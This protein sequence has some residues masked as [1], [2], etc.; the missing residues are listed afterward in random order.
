MIFANRFSIRFGTAV[1]YSQRGNWLKPD[2]TRLYLDYVDN[3]IRSCD[4]ADDD[5]EDD[6]DA[7]ENQ[8]KG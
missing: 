6:A 4:H 3:W 5:D 7:D 2:F 8:G 1:R